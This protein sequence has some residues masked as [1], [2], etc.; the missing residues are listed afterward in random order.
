MMT[1]VGG[2]VGTK[3]R[4]DSGK[5][6]GVGPHLKWGDC[7]QAGHSTILAS[8]VVSGRYNLSRIG[9][10]EGMVF[11]EKGFG[12]VQPSRNKVSRRF[13]C[14]NR[15]SKLTQNGGRTKYNSERGR[16]KPPRDR[17]RKS[18]LDAPTDPRHK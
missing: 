17:D 12:K 6:G 5:G 8:G 11:P 10:R 2:A 3:E 7:P 18:I 13:S 14:V 1:T 15:V 9:F 16:T 4:Q